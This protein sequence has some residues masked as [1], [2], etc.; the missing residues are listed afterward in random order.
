MKTSL[1]SARYCW[2]TIGLLT[3]A[4]IYALAT[5]K[6]ME[7][8]FLAV[9]VLLWL[10]FSKSYAIV[11]LHKFYRWYLH[12]ICGGS[13]HVGPYDTTSGRYI[14]LMDEDEYHEFEKVR[15]EMRHP[16]VPGQP[17]LAQVLRAWRTEAAR[18]RQVRNLEHN[19]KADVLEQRI[20]QVAMC[21]WPCDE[22]DR[23]GK[24]DGRPCVDLSLI[25][26]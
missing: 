9:M 16:S 14:V 13:H 3:I 5:G 15:G 23:S 17:G 10:M 8:A 4:I 12:R 11:A 19:A 20:K 22:C 24:C 26:I 1:F 21:F 25:H 7:A 2:A 6:M 18:L